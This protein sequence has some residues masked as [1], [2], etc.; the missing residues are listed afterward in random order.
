MYLKTVVREGGIPF[1]IRLNKK[2][3]NIRPTKEK[4]VKEKAF[5]TD[6]LDGDSLLS[7]INK[8]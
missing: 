4:P 5:D 7:A 6:V 2:A 8:L 1:E 3:E